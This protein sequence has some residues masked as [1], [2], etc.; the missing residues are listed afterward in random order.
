MCAVALLA[1]TV[2]T[3]EVQPVRLPV[4]GV[5]HTTDAVR[6]DGVLNESTWALAPRVGEIRRIDVPGR[7]PSFP[8]EATLTWDSTYLYV[9]FACT[10]DAPKPRFTRRDDPVW[11][12]D[13]VDV[14]LDPDGDGRRYAEVALNSSNVVADRLVID[15]SSI[16]SSDLEWNLVGLKTAVR[17]HHAGWVAELAIP[18]SAL[19]A[20]GVTGAPKSGSQWAAELYRI[21]PMNDG[22]ERTA[23]TPVR[24]DRGAHD[25]DRFGQLLFMEPAPAH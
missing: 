2:S 15:S 9:A 3:A 17:R 1:V 10:D 6:V 22:P 14:L 7:R 18:W 11:D 8:T 23:W 13:A 20:A 24:A 21:K 25:T 16:S 4:Y 5:R 12:D 19:A